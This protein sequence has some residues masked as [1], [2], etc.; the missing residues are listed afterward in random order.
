[1]QMQVMDQN[2]VQSQIVRDHDISASTAEEVQNHRRLLMSEPKYV[3]DNANADAAKEQIKDEAATSPVNANS[4][5]LQRQRGVG[6]HVSKGSS[7]SGS[8]KEPL[9]RNGH[10][11]TQSG[12]SGKGG[13]G[14]LNGRNGYARSGGKGGKKMNSR[15]SGRY[16]EDL[17]FDTFS[18]FPTSTPIPVSLSGLFLVLLSLKG[19]H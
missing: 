11:P 18:P 7:K 17:R 3:R 2:N 4:R 19:N 16:Y 1:M 10:L 9:G 6:R 13:K 12:K 8:Y 15:S 5:R 14:Y